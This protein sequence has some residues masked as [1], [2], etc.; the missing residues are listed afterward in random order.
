MVLALD[1]AAGIGS[2]CDMTESDVVRHGAKKRDSFA[3][4]HG[5]TTDDQ[6]AYE[7]G[8][9]KLLN[10]DPTVHVEMPGTGGGKLGDNFGRTAGHLF[11]QAAACLGGGGAVTWSCS[12]RRRTGR[13]RPRRP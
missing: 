2:C 1:H 10:R 5:Q 3:N 4:E 6:S 12:R 11:N 7:A 8:T 13:S 9:Q